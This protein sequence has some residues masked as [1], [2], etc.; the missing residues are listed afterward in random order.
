MARFHTT[1]QARE[2]DMRGSSSVQRH[3]LSSDSAWPDPVETGREGTR[4]DIGRNTAAR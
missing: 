3:D 4:K 1:G 2:F